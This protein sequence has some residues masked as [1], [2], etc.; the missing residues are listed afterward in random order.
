MKKTLFYLLLTTTVI[1]LLSRIIPYYQFYLR[2]FDPEYFG[3]LY[4]TS[5]YVVGSSRA[6]GI[7][8]DGLYAFSGYYYITGGDPTQVNFENPPLAKYLIG[9]SILFFGNENLIYLFYSMGVLITVYLLAN[10][11]YKDKLMAILSVSLLAVSN[12]FIIQFIPTSKEQL[13][14]TLLDLPLT[15]FFVTGVLFFLRG[16]TNKRWF[17]FSSAAL[18]LA[19]SSKFFPSLTIIIIVMGIYL[20]ISKSHNFLFWI[21][22]LFIIPVLY[23]LSYSIY[24]INHSLIDFINFNKYLISWRL[25]NPVVVGNI[26]R[27]VF[28]G[29][30]RSWWSDELIIDHEWTIFLPI[31]AILAFVSG[32]YA[33]KKGTPQLKLLFGIILSFITYLAL[34][35]VGV[36]RYLLPIY[37]LMVVLSVNIIRRMLIAVKLL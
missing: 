15:L 13:S 20:F 12:F 1:L 14:I 5:Q 37:P 34:G 30:Y 27:T 4:S 7:G 22:T 26:F 21:V 28:T 16:E 31:I 33:I 6:V 18:G 32:F 19:F 9:I 3:R 23:V 36:A 11:I 10:Q 2:R 25:N 35:S 29:K 24:F 17:V 8:D